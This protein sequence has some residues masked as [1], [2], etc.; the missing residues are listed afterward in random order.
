MT[1]G[2]RQEHM[3]LSQEVCPLPSDVR[4]VENFPQ[5]DTVEQ[6]Q[7]FQD[8][9]NLYRQFL[10]TIARTH[11]QLTNAIEGEIRSNDRTL[12]SSILAAVNAATKALNKATFLAHLVTGATLALEVDTTNSHAAARLQQR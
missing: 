1:S 12:H 11:R 9:I 5:P 2:K 8:L 6:V 4:S 3:V 7:A 10:P